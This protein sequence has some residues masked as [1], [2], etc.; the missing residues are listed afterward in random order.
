MPTVHRVLIAGASIAG[1]TLAY[2]LGHYGLQVVVVERAATLRLGGQNVDVNGPGREVARRMGL[3]EA[4]R[5]RGTGEAGTQFV[6]AANRVQA[7]LAADN[8]NGLTQ[9]LEILRGDL[10]Q[11]LYDHTCQQAEYRFGDFITALAPT[12]TEVQVTFASGRVEAFDV[13]LAADGIR[14]T[15]RHLMFGQEPRVKYL[16]LCSAYLTI[17]RQITDSAWA[18]Y[19]TAPGG[20][21]LYLRPDQQG[22][23]RAGFNFRLP[24]ATYAHLTPADYGRVLR[25]KLTGA[26]W[27]ADR[28]LEALDAGQVPYFDGVGQLKAPRWWVGR[29]AMLGDAAYCA[30]P[31]T[32]SGTTLAMVGAYL[33]AGELATQPSH[34]AAFARYEARLRP[35]V[36]AVQRLPPGIPRLLY[37]T[38]RLG[39][40]VLNLVFKL[41]GSGLGQCLALV[42]SLV[43]KLIGGLGRNR[44]A[45]RVDDHLSVA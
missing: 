12:A 27:E 6:D 15:T 30:S 45:V 43:Q 19:Y 10:V 7:T 13:V 40:R 2:W 42:K 11:L 9:E 32:G 26:G 14:S 24:A 28:L 37:P 17:P 20:R 23:T 3:E 41:V 4:I 31:L 8:P 21:V 25:E 5:A 39:V 33:L 29:L 22:T 1:P 16:G 35:F 34:E 36:E 38:S 44:L 18:R